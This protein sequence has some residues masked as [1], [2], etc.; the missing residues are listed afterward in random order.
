MKWETFFISSQCNDLQW[1]SEFTCTWH[2]PPTL[3]LLKTAMQNPVVNSRTRLP[4]THKECSRTA[5]GGKKEPRLPTSKSDQQSLK[6]V[7]YSRFTEALSQRA[8]CQHPSATTGN[9]LRSCVFAPVDQSSFGCRCSVST[10]RY[11][12]WSCLMCT[13]I[14]RYFIC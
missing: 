3:T 8:C 12:C 13:F 14:W 11:S 9:P 7:E 1:S 2:V 5:G 4:A 6:M 10:N